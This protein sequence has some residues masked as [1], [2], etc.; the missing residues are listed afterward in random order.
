MTA[1]PL[2]Y[3]ITLGRIIREHL[4]SCGGASIP[5]QL[6]LARLHRPDFGECRSCGSVIPYVEIAADPAAELCR[7]CG[8]A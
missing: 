4:E 5:L 7:D 3:Q 8:P 6:A 2:D 1:Y